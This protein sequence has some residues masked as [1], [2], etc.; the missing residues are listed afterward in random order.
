M[1]LF[2]LSF[3]LIYQVYAQMTII[4]PEVDNFSKIERPGFINDFLDLLNKNLPKN[5]FKVEILPV[6]RALKKY[7]SQ[8]AQCFMGG[9]SFL[10]SLYMPDKKSEE[11]IFSE[12]YIT[13]RSKIFAYKKEVC[14]IEKL[15]DKKVATTLQFPLQLFID[16]K[17][18]KAHNDLHS[19]QS[20]MKMLGSNRIDYYVG[21]LPSNRT[22][23]SEIKY[24]TKKDITKHNDTLNCHNNPKN[25]AFIN[26]FNQVFKKLVENGELIQTY[27]KHFPNELNVFYNE[28]IK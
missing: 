24:C 23:D 21:F 18:L 7:L 16:T 2:I 15:S 1:K 11:F 5:S 10:F 8:E 20:A 25:R 27:Q 19:F 14:E 12:P 9:D 3:L 22:F 6:K 13:I 17:K 26:Q 28:I 4:V